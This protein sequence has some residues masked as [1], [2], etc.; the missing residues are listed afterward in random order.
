MTTRTVTRQTARI[1]VVDQ[2]GGKHQVREDTDFLLV[3][4]LDNAVSPPVAG[5]KSYTMEGRHVNKLDDG[6]FETP[7]GLVKLRRL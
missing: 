6:N 1:D 7:D 3:Q 2:H 5:L 4:S